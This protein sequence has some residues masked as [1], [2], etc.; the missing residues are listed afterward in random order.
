M[1]LAVNGIDQADRVVPVG[2]VHR[3]VS[4]NVDAVGK[5]EGAIAPAVQQVAVPVEDED[6]RVLA[7]EGEHSVLGVGGNGADHGEG[8]APPRSLAQFSTTS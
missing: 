6:G 5:G 2:Q 8:V 7:L 1:G 4:V 3:V